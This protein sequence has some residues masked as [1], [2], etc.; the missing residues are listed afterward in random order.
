VVALGFL[1]TAWLWL[2]R[3]RDRRRWLFTVAMSGGL[4]AFAYTSAPWLFVTYYLRF[5]AVAAF[6]VVVFASRLRHWDPALPPRAKPGPLGLALR[7]AALGGVIA[8]NVLGLAARVAPPRSVDMTFPLSHGTYTVLQGGNSFITNPFHRGNPSERLALDL[9]K[10]NSYG[11]RARGLAPTDLGAY[12]VFDDSVF[13]PCDGAV[14]KAVDAVADNP[15][16]H[17]NLAAPAGNHVILRCQGVD[18]LLAHLREGSV[19][20]HPT[21]SVVRGLLIGRVGNSGNTSEPHL[22]ISGSRRGLAVPLT[23]SGRFLSLNTIV[24]RYAVR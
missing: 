3:R 9:V 11:A 23:F 12:A 5:V 2:A 20:V 18:L 6:G 4:V 24:R 7:G 16:G 14:V 13:S 10:L 19:S 8:L 1:P 22:H 17:A 21:E 15:P